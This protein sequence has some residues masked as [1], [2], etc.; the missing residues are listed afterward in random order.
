MKGTRLSAASLGA[1]GVF[2]ASFV[3]FNVGFLIWVDRTYPGPN[4][5]AGVAAFFY[6]IPVALVPAVI[7]FALILLRT[8]HW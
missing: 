4:S 7:A 3:V 2:Q 6:G 8:R 5:T 1:I